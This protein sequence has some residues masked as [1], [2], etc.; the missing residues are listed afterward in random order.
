[1]KAE[2]GNL[3]NLNQ[4]FKD[5]TNE[6]DEIKETQEQANTE[7][8]RLAARKKKTESRRQQALIR[9]LLVA[10]IL[11]LINIIALRIFFR[12]D[13]TPNKI[14]TL[15]DAS[16]NIVAKL[17]DKLIIKAYF[18]DNLPAPY[19]NNRRYLQ[20]ILD[21]YRNASDGKISYEIISPSDEEQLEKDA[22]KYGI[23]PVQVQTF[24]G[25]RAAAMKAYM[26]MVFLYEGKQE[27]IPFIGNTLNLE[28][29]IT[30]T[31]NRMAEEDLKKVG[32]LTGS[33]MPGID[34]ISKVNQ[35]LSKFYNVTN[36]D[37]S[38]NNPIPQDI[39]TLIVFS[40]RHQ[41][42]QMMGMQQQ[43]PA[44]VP[45]HI[46]F[47]VDQY[48]MNGGRVVFL[49]SR[50]NVSSQQ[51]FQIAQTIK[52][53]FEDM[54]QNYGIYIDDDI[55][56]DKE[57]AM[58]SVPVNLGG[59]QMFTQ[60]PFPYYP[61]I[62][63]INRDI[64]SFAG[65]GQIF[66]GFTSSIDINQAQNKGVRV[67]PLLKTSPKTGKSEQFAIVQASGRMFPDSLFKSSELTVGAVYE[68]SFQSF[69]KDKQ[70]PADTSE[71]SSPAPATI[72]DASSETKLILI[73]NSDF[74]LDEFKGPDENLLF[75]ANL[76]DYMTDD[77]GL[78]QIRMKDA[79]PKPLESVEDSTKSIVKYAMLAGPPILVL[80]YGISRWKKKKSNRT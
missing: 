5:M 51:Q 30:A 53:G 66:L 10:G 65:V 59:L 56:M 34:K 79:Q 41:Q 60:M 29:D 11:V 44:E 78:S 32:I 47:A 14:Y 25:D 19:N 15:S 38:K 21:D 74:P 62:F 18:T 9:I 40:P 75:F 48:I 1:L 64:P 4:H 68:G 69:Y 6:M 16:K 3:E 76:I 49:L 70:I 67:T 43:P 28:Y 27:T 80:L 13:L 72:K 36:V 20:E 39:K 50:I 23:Q 2:N 77:I 26:G 31:I 42:N 12:W 63:N 55:L 8:K 7:D 46:K 45:E 57:C 22:Q 37:A 61:R 33:N 52:T 17:D 71:G 24:E 54:L 58:V 73:G 35:H